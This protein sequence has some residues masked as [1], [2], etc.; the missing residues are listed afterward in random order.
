VARVRAPLTRS[1]LLETQRLLALAREGYD[2]LDRKREI[3]LAELLAVT[4]EAE[5]A[6]EA[7]AQGFQAAYDALASARMAMGVDR[8][9]WTALAVRT[10]VDLKVTDRSTMGAVI[11]TINCTIAG[12]DPPYSLSGTSAEF[13]P[14]QWP[15]SAPLAEAVCAAAER[16]TAVLRLSREI[17]KTQRRVNALG[18]VVIP[19]Q[20]S[21]IKQVREALEDTEREGFFRAKTLRRRNVEKGRLRDAE[22]GSHGDGE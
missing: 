19:Q 6:R 9:G 12:E 17:R 1:T 22:T 3:L 15:P 16:E 21:I 5:Q 11:P 4:P 14:G 13:G 7:M 20:E 18:N 8:V 10:R 2:L